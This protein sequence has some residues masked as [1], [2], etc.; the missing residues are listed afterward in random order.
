MNFCFII[1]VYNSDMYIN[2]C[3][4]SVKMQ[5]NQ[6]WR[7]I[8]VDDCSTDDTRE[9]IRSNMDHR[10]T[11]IENDKRHRQA[12]SRNVAYKQAQDDE[13][14]VM[15]DGDDWLFDKYVLNRLDTL[16]TDQPELNLTYGGYVKYD[17]GVLNSTVHG[18][19]CFPER[20][21]SDNSYR[22]HAWIST[23]LRTMRGRVIKN[24]PEHHLKFQGEWLKGATDQAE[25]FYA[26]EQSEGKH[27]NNGFVGYVYNVESSKRF[28]SSWQGDRTPEWDHYYSS[29]KQ[30]LKGL[31]VV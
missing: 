1:P 2:K 15:L 8:I 31:N 21:V 25:M 20:V 12:Y 5:T 23:H 28:D 30:H 22:T 13:V 11:L 29:V 18:T 4:E 17:N 7:A 27:Q 26:L 14:C 6:N 16:Y 10:F 19:V 24:I 3:I 9:V